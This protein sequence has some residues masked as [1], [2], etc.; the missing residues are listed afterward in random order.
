METPLPPLREVLAG[1]RLLVTGTT[2]F[3]GKV[4]LARLLDAVPDVAVV[5]CV[6][7]AGEGGESEAQRRFRSEVLR[8]P[9][10]DALGDGVPDE[11]LGRKLRP[12]PGDL[13]EPFLGL[14]AGAVEALRGEIDAVV[15]CAG[16]VDFEAS[17]ETAYR[18][19]ILGPQHVLALTH[20]V[21]ARFLIHVS[22]CYVPGRCDGVCPERVEVDWTPYGGG[23]FSAAREA[24]EIAEVIAA[25]HR[26]VSR[27]D[28]DRV[29]LDEA[30]RTLAKESRRE[31]RA[32]LEEATADA[33]ERWLVRRLSV[34]GL[35]RAERWGWPNTYTYTKSLGEQLL[36]GAAGSLPFTIV[37]PAVIESAERFPFQGW[38]QGVN[39]S[40]P[41]V[42]LAKQGFRHWPVKRDLVLDVVPVDWVA[43]GLLVALASGLH[44][45]ARRRPVIQIGVCARNPFTMARL[46]EL[47]ALRLRADAEDEGSVSTLSSLIGGPIDPVTVEEGTYRAL[48]PPGLARIARALRP[49]LEAVEAPAEEGS[50]GTL[51]RLAR[52]AASALRGL[53]ESGALVERLIDVYR[54]YVSELD[55]TFECHELTKLAARLPEE[56]RERFGFA[57]ERLDWRHYWM[58]VHLP[59]LE[60][61]SFPELER[62]RRKGGRRRPRTLVEALRRS[63]ER[64]GARPL[65]ITPDRERTREEVL[66]DAEARAE[67]LAVEKWARG[68]P[69]AVPLEPSDDFAER[70]LAALLH[71]AIP[72]LDP[73][74]PMELA[75]PSGTVLV[76]GGE[77]IDEAG[78]R[79][80]I[81][82]AQAAGIRREDRVLTVLDPGDAAARSA[83][84]MLGWLAPWLAGGACV[85]DAE[86]RG[87]I[88]LGVLRRQRPTFALAPGPLWSE[89]HR[90]LLDATQGEEAGLTARLRQD[91]LRTLER[92]L[93]S[94][95]ARATQSWVVPAGRARLGALSRGL[96]LGGVVPA[97][98]REAWRG[99]GVA[100]TEGFALAEAGGLVALDRRARSEFEPLEG[101]R[102]SF[103]E[104]EKATTGLSAL[105]PGTGWLG[106]SLPERPVVVETPWIGESVGSDASAGERLRAR[107]FGR[108]CDRVRLS[109]GNVVDLAVLER[110][111]GFAPGLVRELACVRLPGLPGDEIAAVV[112]PEPSVP[113]DPEE[114]QRD[115]RYRFE[116]QSQ[117][118][119]S[120]EHISRVI[121][122]AGPLPRH[123]D[124]DVDRESLAAG[125]LEAAAPRA[126]SRALGRRRA[127]EAEA[128]P[129]PDDLTRIGRR[130]FDA[131]LDLVYRRGFHVR[132]FGRVHIP[133][134]RA[135]LVVS[136]HTSH[137]D[138]GAVRFAMGDAGN[139]LSVLGARDYFFAGTLSRT[140]FEEFTEVEPFER[141][142]T[143]LGSM[144]NSLA[145]LRRGRSVLVFPEGS[146]SVTGGLRAFQAGVGLLALQSGMDVL[147]AYVAGSHRALPKGAWLP[148][149]R[150]LVV[151][152]GPPLLAAELRT[153]SVG[154][155]GSAAAESVVARLEAAVA[156][157][158]DDEARRAGADPERLRRTVESLRTRFA[159]DEVSA[160]RSWYL[161]LGDGPAGKWTV[162]VSSGGVEVVEGRASGDADC[163]LK[164]PPE[165]FVRM[166]EEGYVPPVSDFV[167]GRVKTNRPELLREFQRVF[168]L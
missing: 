61:W 28:V 39:T 123:A 17:L 94:A 126:V 3:L 35:D 117:T 4:F 26:E 97:G 164:A 5:H 138:T 119:V 135:V 108:G 56:D 144:K 116:A 38:N 134:E 128:I 92:Q 127:R 103:L 121:F 36:A 7:R 115:I 162:R 98:L 147:P 2:G 166:V 29:C 72:V 136:N 79:D 78:L 122:H 100:L 49:A 51:A 146:R 148:R 9:V 102:F 143:S 132:V 81:E 48:A 41:L 99:F 131:G 84:L 32:N 110:R 64:D 118:A 111:Y 47:T 14:P 43:D 6:V 168:G 129:L 40:A 133:P 60:R 91:L 165:V 167:A 30:R 21:G 150:E 52:T 151:R 158:R 139:R 155:R 101:V 130:A 12:L 27:Q 90:L 15:S 67:K 160:P 157:L 154:L 107:I 1:K 16:L 66:R 149:S 57:P 13:A 44:E 142:G 120:H 33:R 23:G 10:F 19:N 34:E 74:D 114:V 58:E 112:V 42:Y 8:S 137:L 153:A 22:T 63:C 54:P 156:A 80:W 53:E 37:R 140:F 75:T 109:D 46:V 163:V 106:V 124:G 93:G 55:Y 71:G 88:R 82:R 62:R 89:L 125:I 50:P 113:R 105:L 76:V 65:V 59:G 25:V 95:A 70:F 96:T 85:V 104:E 45:P 145:L 73:I 69:L 68:R 141:E 152:F 31:T 161:S 83:T 20:A 159:R 18:T 77:A 87:A 86:A 11:W 24:E